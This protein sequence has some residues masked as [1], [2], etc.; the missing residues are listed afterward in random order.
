MYVIYIHTYF[1]TKEAINDG[2]TQNKITTYRQVLQQFTT[3]VNSE[4]NSHK[5]LVL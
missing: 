1:Q 4:Q 5:K 2:V 3:H